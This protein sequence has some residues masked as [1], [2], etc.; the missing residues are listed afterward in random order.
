MAR[1]PRSLPSGRGKLLPASAQVKTGQE[2]AGVTVIGR[3]GR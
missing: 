1:A 2:R 3:G